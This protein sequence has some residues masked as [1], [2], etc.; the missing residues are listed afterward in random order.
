MWVR[1][2]SVRLKSLV[3]RLLGALASVRLS[4]SVKEYLSSTTTH[5]T[6]VADAVA[7]DVDVVAP[8]SNKTLVLCV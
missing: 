5:H 7:V 4:I 2:R 1:K 3:Q 8:T 6:I